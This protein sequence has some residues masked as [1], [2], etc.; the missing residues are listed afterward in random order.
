MQ[1]VFYKI[2]QTCISQYA[3]HWKYYESSSIRTC[4]RWVLVDYFG[5]VT[6]VFVP[7]RCYF[8]SARLVTAYIE[9]DRWGIACC[10]SGVGTMK[11]S[12]F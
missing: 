8:S 10:C 5:S 9:G 1:L 2:K 3:K 11:A 4:D 6:S 7:F 12:S